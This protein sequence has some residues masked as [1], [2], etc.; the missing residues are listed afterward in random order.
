VTNEPGHPDNLPQAAVEALWRGNLIEAIKLV[1]LERSIGLKEA[2]QLVDA[3]VRT[4]PTLQRKMEE[5]QAEA[6]RRFVRWLIVVLAFATA[7][8]YLLMQGK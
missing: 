8:T 7:I 6:R 1:R 5:I 4:K 2:K 3:Y